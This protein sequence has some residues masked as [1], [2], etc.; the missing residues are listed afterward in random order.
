MNDI[1][2]ELQSCLFS[3]PFFVPFSPLTSNFN[4]LAA[5]SAYQLPTLVVGITGS[6]PQLLETLCKGTHFYKIQG[7]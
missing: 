6:I 2:N 7:C 3:H 1:I 5:C 4:N